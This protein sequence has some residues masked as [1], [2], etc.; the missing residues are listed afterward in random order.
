M[1]AFFGLRP[2]GIG[3]SD[4]LAGRADVSAAQQEFRVRDRDSGELWI[5]PA[6]AP[7]RQS[8]SL[9]ESP[10]FEL[11]LA[12]AE[13]VFDLIIVDTPPLNIIADAATVVAN[14]GAVLLVVRGGV[15][16]REALRLT[17]ERLERADGPVAGIV[18]NDVRLPARY[19]SYSYGAR[20]GS[21]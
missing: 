1:A 11:L 8:A 16:D 14:M 15:T 20:A 4:V 19:S 6:G 3:L 21:S 12:G 10:R 2:D 18:L 9:L 13:S 7:T 17:L 5:L